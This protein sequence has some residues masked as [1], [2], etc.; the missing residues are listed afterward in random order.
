MKSIIS[1]KL[2]LD[3][4]LYSCKQNNPWSKKGGV[5]MDNQLMLPLNVNDQAVKQIE[6]VFVTIAKKV[7]NDVVNGV[8]HKPYLNKK[9][10][11][12]YIGI[13]F[14]TLKKFEEMGLPVTNINGMQFIRK[15]DIDEFM[16]EHTIT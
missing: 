7:A 10:A 14:N 16:E 13:S 6:Q 3:I 1:C 9:E 11:C 15:M 5:Y 12:E 4:I 2:N 8:N